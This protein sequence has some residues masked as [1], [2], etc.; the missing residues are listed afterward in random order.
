MPPGSLSSVIW[1]VCGGYVI[2]LK[3]SM[4]SK[5]QAPIRPKRVILLGKQ[6]TLKKTPKLE[7]S[8]EMTDALL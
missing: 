1:I 4:R 7:V 6:H 3:V 8:K 2:E 5:R